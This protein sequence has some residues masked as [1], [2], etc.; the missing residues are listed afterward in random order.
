MQLITVIS[1]SLQNAIPLIK[2]YKDR[3]N[4]HYI[5]YD[6][7]D[8]SYAKRLEEGL[9]KL[10]YPFA[11]QLFPIDEDSQASFENLFASLSHNDLVL[12]LHNDIDAN[13]SLQLSNFVLKNGGKVF[14]YDKQ[15]NSYNILTKDSMQNCKITHNLTLHEFLTLNGFTFSFK[16]PTLHTKRLTEKIFNSFKK[17]RAAIS[18]PSSGKYADLYALIKYYFPT[19]ANIISQLGE[20][21]EEY[22][23][24]KLFALD[25]DDIMLNA[26]ISRDDVS[27][28]F[29]VL[30]I[31]NNSIYVVECKFRSSLK[32]NEES[33]SIIY[34][35]DALLDLFG[36]DTKG[37]IVHIGQTQSQLEEE[38]DISKDF[39]LM[40]HKRAQIG[41][42][43]I[44]H[45]HHFD[46][47]S[48]YNKLSKMGLVR[49]AFLLGGCDLEM[50][51]IKKLL[52]RYNQKYFSKMLSWGAKL[53]SYK[54]HFDKNFSFYGIEL[55]PDITPPPHYKT[56]DHHNQHRN[57]PSA[58]KQVCQILH[59]E[60][61][62]FH[63]AVALND[64]GYIP[65]L[66]EHGFGHHVQSIRRL[67]SKAQGVSK[68]DEEAAF[69]VQ[70][71]GELSVVKTDASKFSPIVDRLYGS[72]TNLLIYNDKEF[73]FY[74]D[75]K[76]VEKFKDKALY[77]SK[78]FFG[79]ENLGVI[80]LI[81]QLFAS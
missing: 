49:R 74:G 58:I 41:N 3:I 14:T 16:Q 4:K 47:Q 65:A 17:L 36:C 23:Y 28:E 52:S 21:F 27:N 11:S 78:N 2:E 5:V 42:I 59:I 61:N 53:S 25:I 22:I 20:A 76:V 35:M 75:E 64:T 33:T 57:N 43:Y 71:V 81:L 9:Q 70:K 60:P 39:S 62:R 44:Y 51:A 31:K 19:Q 46:P 7:A 37:L 24:W 29:D 55:V 13:I 45:K 40:A 12:N 73:T 48:F 77:Y 38:F 80:D 15:D 26:K 63:K 67:D 50:A 66:I 54:E 69:E 79:G 8:E 72:Y 34:K 1:A 18:A 32:R 10:N 56:I 68:E 6:I 30:M